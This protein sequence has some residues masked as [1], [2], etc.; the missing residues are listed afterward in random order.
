MDK[1]ISVSLD[2]SKVSTD[3]K[4]KQDNVD[5]YIVTCLRES[6]KLIKNYAKTHHRF[7]SRTGKLERAIKYMVI[8]RLKQGK[9]YVDESMTRV[10]P[11]Y[12][13]YS[14]AKFEMSGTGIHPG[15]NGEYSI[16][17]RYKKALKFFDGR[18][19][20]HV[21]HHPG[22]RAD[23]FLDRA[24]RNTKLEVKYIFNEGLHQLISGSNS[25]LK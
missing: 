1:T 18:I 21:N 17:P 3:I 8:A 16:Y 14:Y 25:I 10:D 7:S 5:K 2:S 11:K 6:C 24:V 15:G 9:V 13:N 19:V 12:G 22:S 4:I 23:K 20:N